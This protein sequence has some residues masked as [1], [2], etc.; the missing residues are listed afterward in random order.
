MAGFV[1]H[2]TA[3]AGGFH[4]HPA[5]GQIFMDIDERRLR[6]HLLELV[7]CQL[8]E[9]GTAGNDD[10]LEVEVGQGIL[11]AVEEHAIVVG[12]LL[13]ARVIAGGRGRV[14]AADIGGREHD[15]QPEI[16]EHGFRG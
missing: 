8:I 6:K 7:F 12:D 15:I 13:P 3:A 4:T 10:G 16:V 11:D 14:A 2:E 5:F 9:T 1:I